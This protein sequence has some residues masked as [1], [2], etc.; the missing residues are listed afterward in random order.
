[1]ARE[2]AAL[3]L[4]R[5]D[6]APREPLELLALRAQLPFDAMALHRRSERVGDRLEEVA[7]VLAVRAPR[8][9]VR[10]EDAV[11]ATEAVGRRGHAARHAE[12]AE[13][14]M[15]GKAR[16]GG[17]VLGDDRLARGARE[18]REPSPVALDPKPVHVARVAGR[19][20]KDEAVVGE[21]FEHRAILD[22]ERP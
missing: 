6:E 5:L 1:L 13:R 22:V 11:D 7:I 18:R 15:D 2:G 4:L 16:L 14:G 17:E 12:L 20:A 21:P 3:R 19:G 10:A 9:R 8:L